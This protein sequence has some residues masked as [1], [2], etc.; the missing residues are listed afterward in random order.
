ML[1]ALI[2][3]IVSFNVTK[4][5][6]CG[7]CNYSIE[8]RVESPK[9]C[10]QAL[11]TFNSWTGNMAILCASTSLMI[12]TIA[13]WERK[14]TV[15]VPLIILCLAHWGLLYHDQ[16]SHPEIYFLRNNGLRSYHIWLYMYRSAKKLFAI[17]PMA[18]SVP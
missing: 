12:R 7:V 11:Y 14:L 6:N 16:L 9:F 8:L 13:I 18:P 5:V 1:W 15:V 2:G 17:G 3:L 4:E 10:L